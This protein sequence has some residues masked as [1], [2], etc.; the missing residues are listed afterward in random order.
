MNT[1]RITS[2]IRGGEEADPKEHQSPG[3]WLQYS[4]NRW[5]A[6]WCAVL[7]SPISRSHVNDLPT[8]NSVFHWIISGGIKGYRME[9]AGVLIAG[10]LLNETIERFWSRL[11]S[12]AT[13]LMPME[14]PCENHFVQATKWSRSRQRYHNF[15][16]I[17]METGILGGKIWR[18][19][20][21]KVFGAP[22]KFN[23]ELLHTKAIRWV[24]R[25]IPEARVNWINIECYKNFYFR[26]ALLQ[27]WLALGLQ[28]RLWLLTFC[29]SSLKS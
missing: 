5:P 22:K 24:Y 3:S 12:V 6:N 26:T 10:E 20:V 17:F 18:Y 27:A 7:Q 16:S 1:V 2:R 23:T 13:T 4:T 8:L 11:D 14:D 9:E 28:S 19:G 29:N 15:T 25:G 21:T